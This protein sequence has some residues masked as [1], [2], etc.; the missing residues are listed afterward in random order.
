MKIKTTRDL[1]HVSRN[2]SISGLGE[3][4]WLG[5]NG[6]LKHPMLAITDPKCETVCSTPPDLY[7][8]SSLVP[9]KAADSYQNLLEGL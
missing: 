3:S 6:S 5:P 9:K 2:S 1:G 8:T 7:Y 4:R